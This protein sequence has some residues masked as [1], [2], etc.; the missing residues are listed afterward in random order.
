MSPRTKEPKPPKA[1][2]KPKK[3][4]EPKASKDQPKAHGTDDRMTLTE[5]L[6]ELRSRI[7]KS[8]LAVAICAT[9]IFIFWDPVLEFLRGPYD[10]FCRAAK[11]GTCLVQDGQGKF[12]ATDPLGPFL[13][14]TRVA[15]WGG[16]VL[17]LPVVLWQIWRFVVPGLHAKEKKYA[18][19]FVVASVV[20]FAFGSAI[21]YWLLSKSLQFLISWGGSGFQVAFTIDK[22]IRLLTL[23]MLAFG[24]GFL[25]PVLLVFLQLVGAVTPRTLLKYWRHA[26][27]AVI[28]TAAVITPSGD[29]FSLFGLAV[30]M[31]IFYWA[32]IGIGWL[33]RRNKPTAD[34]AA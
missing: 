9:L 20:L 13:A 11:E 12:L 1:P 31:W 15:G 23:M 14:R 3:A 27:V 2:K 7:I 28:L 8:V 5:H 17:A 30:P 33:I 22:Y 29:L 24:T 16:V 4:K 25:F 26:T 21:A 10:S 34:A 6:A 19:P 18:A 32:S